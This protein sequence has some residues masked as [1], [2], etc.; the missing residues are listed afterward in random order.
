MRRVGWLVAVVVLAGCGGGAA[1]SGPRDAPIA[2]DRP[3]PAI[4]AAD[5]P[6]PDWV[7]ETLRP[8][9]GPAASSTCLTFSRG[10]GDTT[11][12]SCSSEQTAT[13]E[14]R[15]Q[16]RLAAIQPAAGSEPRVVATL[17][18]AHDGTASF[19]AWEAPGGPCWM[20][21][22]EVGGGG[23]GGGPH[24]PCADPSCD[25]F[26]LASSGGGGG[27]GDE[28]VL[29]GTVPAAAAAVRVTLAD[30]SQ[31]TYPLDG[32]LF[33]GATDRRVFVLDLGATD[34]WRKVELVEGGAVTRTYAIPKS[35]AA[36]EDCQAK[37]GPPPQPVMTPGDHAG[38]AAEIQPYTDAIDACVRRLDPTP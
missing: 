20:T 10:G 9:S 1:V 24:G 21:E 13:L 19:A 2:P 8:P 29:S 38:M 15:R 7:G 26:C 12:A 32:P 28:Y 36:V 27:A 11:T 16:A 22:V 33:P 31:A 5:E 35:L 37:L 3:A 17:G 18:L 34:A 6:A 30:G 23:G 25:A 4:V 14:T